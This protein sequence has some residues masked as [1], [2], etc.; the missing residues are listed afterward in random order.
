MEPVALPDPFLLRKTRVVRPTEALFLRRLVEEIK[1]LA[2]AFLLHLLDGHE[3]QSR[4]IDAITHAGRLWTVV[5]NVAEVG[6][7][8]FGA[9]FRA[10]HEK[11]LISFLD[12]MSPG[13]LA[14]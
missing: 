10:L 5:K 1:I 3:A 12:D 7:A 2:V 4:G 13:R 11:R 6:V 8:L 9:D 14:W